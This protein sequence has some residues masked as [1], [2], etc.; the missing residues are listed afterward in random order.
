M[1]GQTFT[2]TA[3]VLKRSSVGEKDRIVTLLSPEKGKFLVIA[4]GARS[5]QSSRLGLLEP[6]ALIKAHCVDRSS[7]PI[8][9]QVVAIDHLHAQLDSL[10]KIKALSQ[11]LE[12]LEQ[13]FVEEKMPEVVYQKILD[14]RSLVVT[15]PQA[16]ITIQ[17]HLLQLLAQLG[18]ID[19]D[20]KLD[21]NVSQFV[22]RLT[23]KKL[24]SFKYLTVS[25]AVGVK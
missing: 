24:V 13:L 2:V 9:T 4:K 18:F 19:P 20:Q 21:G 3:L 1:S 10:I 5:L 14:L 15:H 11:L 8:L 25:A 7:W 16:R 12:L 6:G 23:N 22:S 17:K